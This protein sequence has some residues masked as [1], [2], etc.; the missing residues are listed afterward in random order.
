MNRGDFI[1]V[2]A[3]LASANFLVVPFS[4]PVLADQ[5]Q[6]N[7]LQ[8]SPRSKVALQA[9]CENTCPLEEAAVNVVPYQ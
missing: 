2:V 5:S 7:S 9:P 8:G 1:K 6:K 3:G 4:S